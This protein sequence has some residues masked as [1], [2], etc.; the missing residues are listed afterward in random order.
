MEQQTFDKNSG[1]KLWRKEIAMVVE[2]LFLR[3]EVK[4]N[5]KVKVSFIKRR[6]KKV[7]VHKRE[8]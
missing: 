3:F 6:N 1:I 7:I 4:L 8:R 5:P 2:L